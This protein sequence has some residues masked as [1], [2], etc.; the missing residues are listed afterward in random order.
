MSNEPWIFFDDDSYEIA[1]NEEGLKCLKK[2]I[3]N[4][5]EDSGASEKVV[6]KEEEHFSVICTEK[7][8]YFISGD[9]PKSKWWEGIVGGAIMVWFLVLPFVAI[10]LILYLVFWSPSPAQCNQ[11]ILHSPV[12][13]KCI[14]QS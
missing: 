7:G 4:A 12:K 10:G 6:I 9:T 13:T 5:I 3:D 2:Y 14:V 8:E 11:K 1:G